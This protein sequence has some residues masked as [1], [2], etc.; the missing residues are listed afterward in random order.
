MSSN[1]K[2]VLLV[3][4]REKLNTEAEEGDE[5]MWVPSDLESESELEEEEE[6]EKKEADDDDSGGEFSS[7][8]T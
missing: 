1:V 6:S 8:G 3:S 7:E 5:E 4:D 2:W